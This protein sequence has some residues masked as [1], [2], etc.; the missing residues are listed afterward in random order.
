VLLNISQSPAITSAASTAFTVGGAGT[1]AVTSTGNPT[2]ALSESGTLPGGVTFHDNGDGT[3]SLS[4]TPVAGSGG[5][6]HLTIRAHNGVSP[7]ATQSFTLT[8]KQPPAIT[9]AASAT[10]AVGRAGTFTVT[11]TGYPTPALTDPGELPGGV[12]FH[13]NGNGTASLS[14]TPVAGSAGVYHLTIRAHNGVSPDA[15]QAFTL[16][17]VNAPEPPENGEPKLPATGTP[18]LPLL[19]SLAG[20]LTLIGTGLYVRARRRRR[21]AD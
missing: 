8:V 6:Y 14:G 17:V 1:F 20:M 18:S 21:N 16:T 15:T 11:S 13:D 3:A 2:S 12:T 5:V 9:S 10:F 4:G 19:T 7:D